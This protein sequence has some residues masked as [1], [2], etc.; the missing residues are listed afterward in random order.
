MYTTN[1]EHAVNFVRLGD[2]NDFVEQ[3]A[4]G[5]LKDSSTELVKEL[6]NLLDKYAQLRFTH[7][8]LTPSLDKVRREVDQLLEA[9]QFLGLQ[10]VRHD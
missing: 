10:R 5:E 9:L 7:I 2:T 3:P 8:P 4:L 1:I 6:N